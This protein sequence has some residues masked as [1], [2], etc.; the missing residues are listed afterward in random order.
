MKT[1]KKG[2]AGLGPV[3]VS[4]AMPIIV[5]RRGSKIPTVRAV[6]WS[7][8][9]IVLHMPKMRRTSSLPS[10]QKKHAWG[11]RGLRLVGLMSTFVMRRSVGSM[12]VMKRKKV[13]H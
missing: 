1:G 9:L 10:L 5:S 13:F 11:R 12:L 4:V 3:V 7:A 2:V 8:A 6:E